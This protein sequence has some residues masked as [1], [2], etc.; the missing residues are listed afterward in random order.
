MQVPG[1]TRESATTDCW[2][3]C[4]PSETNQMARPSALLSFHYS[5][6]MSA[7]VLPRGTLC[8]P[9]SRNPRILPSPAV[10]HCEAV[11]ATGDQV[12]ERDM[13]ARIRC[14]ILLSTWTFSDA[15]ALAEDMAEPAE[16]ACFAGRSSWHEDGLADGGVAEETPPCACR[17]VGDAHRPKLICHVTSASSAR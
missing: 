7:L 5:N 9:W 17:K 13:R 11:W 16:F 6:T 15:W 8:G 2:G 14:V 3:S 10:W 12:F 4:P 1:P